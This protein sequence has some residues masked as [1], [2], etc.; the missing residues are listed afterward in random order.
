MKTCLSVFLLAVGVSMFGLGESLSCYSCPDG[1]TE[2]CEKVQQC[3]AAETLCLK[4]SDNTGKTYSKCLQL[5]DCDFQKLSATFPFTPASFRC[6]PSNLCNSAHA[7]AA[8]PL[9][10]LLAGL[11]AL[12]WGMH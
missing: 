8:R 12:Y 11:A 6:C 4:L 3:S 10:G 7:T 2:R 1:S 9:I 5:E